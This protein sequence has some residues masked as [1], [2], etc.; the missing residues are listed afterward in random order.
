[1][2]TAVVE[3]LS[4]IQVLVKLLAADVRKM[5][6]LL[7]AFSRTAA[8]AQ[9]QEER[10]QK[11]SLSTPLQ[12]RPCVAFWPCVSFSSTV[13]LHCLCCPHGK[14]FF[15]TRNI[16][17]KAFSLRSSDSI[18]YFRQKSAAANSPFLWSHCWFKFDLAPDNGINNAL[19]LTRESHHFIIIFSE[20]SRICFSFFTASCWNGV[21]WYVCSQ[22]VHSLIL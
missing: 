2:I 8:R 14:T 6:Q 20:S 3:C 19:L 22:K 10:T 5:A 18:V 16:R 15:M 1:M 9:Q 17:W 7:L 12:C 11:M 4:S 21:P 13:Q